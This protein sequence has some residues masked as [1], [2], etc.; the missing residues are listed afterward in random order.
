MTRDKLLDDDAM[1]FYSYFVRRAEEKGEIPSHI[2]FT[3]VSAKPFIVST[4]GLA[5]WSLQLTPTPLPEINYGGVVNGASGGS[6]IS[7]GSYASIYGTMLAPTTASAALTPLPT[8]LGNATV[9]VN[10]VRAPAYYVSALQ[11]NFQ[12]PF[13]TA[14]GLATVS[15]SS[16]VLP[17]SICWV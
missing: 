15:I 12:V 3:K 11:V 7:P 2:G 1:N 10:G 4:R 14:P 16:Y 17:S 5:N 8:S 6:V 13:A 9:L